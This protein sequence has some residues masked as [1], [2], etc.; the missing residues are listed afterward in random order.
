MYH[1]VINTL[2]AVEVIVLLALLASKAIVFRKL[3]TEVIEFSTFTRWTYKLGAYNGH[4]RIA[5]H[6][7]CLEPKLVRNPMGWD[8]VF[9]L[10]MAEEDQVAFMHTAE[11]HV[12]Y[13]DKRLMDLAVFREVFLNNNRNVKIV[14][15][16]LTTV[17]PKSVDVLPTLETA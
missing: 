7:H 16:Q 10:D 4:V 11:P 1:F 15:N 6:E 3:S 8:F 9:P 17:T 12:W 5:R 2:L 13:G 14:R